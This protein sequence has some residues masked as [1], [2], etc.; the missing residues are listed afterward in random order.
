MSDRLTPWKKKNGNTT[1]IKKGDSAWK[2]LLPLLWEWNRKKLYEY[3]FV[4]SQLLYDDIMHIYIYIHIYM[5]MFE[6][7]IS[8][9]FF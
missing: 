6:F 9:L 2:G 3:I 4:N 1:I 7:E 5:Y 8:I